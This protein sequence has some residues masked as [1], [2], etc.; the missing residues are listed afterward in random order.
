M[1]F[2]TVGLLLCSSGGPATL[3]LQPPP[4]SICMVS[5]RGCW[6]HSGQVSQIGLELHA[7][8]SSLEACSLESKSIWQTSVLDIFLSISQ[9]KK[10][11]VEEAYLKPWGGPV[12]SEVS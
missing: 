7:L 5:H 4:Q 8:D 11:R 1:S 12:G 10:V 2:L 6:L 9:V 3:G